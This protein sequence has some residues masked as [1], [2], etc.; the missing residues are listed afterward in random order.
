[1]SGALHS[2]PTVWVARVRSLV[3]YRQAWAW[4][5]AVHA[6]RVTGR[7]PDV[8]F[9]LSHPP[10]VTLGRRGR[11]SALRRSQEELSAQG[12]ELHVVERGGDATYHGPGQWVVYPVLRLGQADADAH[13]HLYNLEELAIRTCAAFGVPAR[14]RAGMAGAW[15]PRGKIAAIGFAIRR[16]VTFHGMSFNVAPNPNGF[17][18]IIPCGLAGEPVASLADHLSAVPSMD[19]VADVM[20]QLFGTIF[21]RRVEYVGDRPSWPAELAELCPEEQPT[22]P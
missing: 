3:P 1:V 16:W 14:R 8:A 11:T 15:T 9:W 5:R 10:T 6:A 22:S 2:P 17:E 20:I 4:Q 7:I 21:G 18:W 12:V 13:G 19:D